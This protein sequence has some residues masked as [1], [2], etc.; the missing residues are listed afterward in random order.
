MRLR[1]Q[2]DKLIAPRRG[3]PPA[4]PSGYEPDPG[5]P[6]VFLIKLPPCD[7]REERI[8]KMPCCDVIKMWCTKLDVPVKRIHCSERLCDK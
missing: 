5:D 7:Y 2:N 4:A 6:Y 1:K 8:Y 3:K